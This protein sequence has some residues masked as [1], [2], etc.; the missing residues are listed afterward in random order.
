MKKPT[1]QSFFK[2]GVWIKEQQ[3]KLTM[4]ALNDDS[5]TMVVPG[6]LSSKIFEFE[7]DMIEA[8]YG[9]ERTPFNA[10]VVDIS[11]VLK[12]LKKQFDNIDLRM[13]LSESG[14]NLF[15]GS[16]DEIY[17]L[18]QKFVSSALPDELNP[19]KE[20]RIYI[21]TSILEGH[22]CIIF[23]DSL[24]ISTPAKV[25]EEIR[26]IEK[27]LKGEVSFKSTGSSKTYYD[28]MIPSKE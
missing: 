21:N 7:N 2:N 13:P 15:K 3:G 24:S 27:D 25:K 11:E 19:G 22:L 16:F 18:L 10:E 14:D 12:R 28:I 9:E 17:Q 26:F 5:T 23:R 20:Q 1:D 6:T 4:G 8:L